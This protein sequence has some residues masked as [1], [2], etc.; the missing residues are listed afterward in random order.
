MPA[1]R[2]VRRPKSAARRT[3]TAA[4]MPIT[5]PNKAL[6]AGNRGVRNDWQEAAWDA[7]EMVGELSY[8]GS[9]RAN[10]CS[11]CRLV[12]S[13]VDPVTGLPTGATENPRVSDIVRAIAGGPLG[14]AQYISRATECLTV[15]GE[16]WTLVAYLG[17]TDA[18]KNPVATWLVLNRGDIKTS[19]GSG[20]GSVIMPDGEEYT[21]KLPQD[22]IFR[23]WNP[24]AR[25]A[26]EADSP[27][28]ACLPTLREIIRTTKTIDKANKSRL[29]GNGILFVPHEMSLPS[30]QAPTSAGKPDGAPYTPPPTMVG[31]PAVDQLQT[32]LVQ[33]AMVAVE[34]EESMSAHM[35]VIAAVP[36]EQTKNIL[37]LKFDDQVTEVA[38][39]TRTDAIKRL[40]MGLDVSPERLLGVGE[41]SNH[42]S[43]WAIG[44]EDVRLH[45]APVME[46]ICQA[47]NEQVLRPM[48]EREGIDPDAYLIWYDSSELTA[49]PD[50]TDEA[51]A[52]F[53]RGAITADAYRDFLGLG[54]SG[55][56][57]ATLD[58]WQQWAVDK[59]SQDPALMQTLL[60]LLPTLDGVIEA[61]MFP[62]LEAPPPV[63]EEVPVGAAAQE[64]PGTENERFA[65]RRNGK[66]LH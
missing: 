4:S 6:R 38:I 47:L 21:L 37:H 18:D 46:T 31:T 22:T 63:I 66:V 39:K 13:D 8:Y 59:V 29:I 55:Y 49:D 7:Y 20:G 25:K 64:E 24:R 5:D 19:G 28:R 54:E 12:A 57:F 48:L 27:V 45:I 3:L 33:T 65:L 32:L 10:S 9:W 51:T 42:W 34:D 23:V 62:A 2:V 11:R 30:S 50:K 16:Y 53:D 61:D 41:T 14:Q 17:A 58:G 15:P 35:P 52:A 1:L 43:A 26:W 36:G 56:D 44:D 40:A 60:P